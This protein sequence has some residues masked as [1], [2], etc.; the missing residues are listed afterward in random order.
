M[1]TN[2]PS[3]SYSKC[4]TE[5]YLFSCEIIFIPGYSLQQHLCW[6]KR[7]RKMKDSLAVGNQVDYGTSIL[8]GTMKT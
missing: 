3:N 5:I 8:C 4:L 7:E 1:H 2:L 6:G